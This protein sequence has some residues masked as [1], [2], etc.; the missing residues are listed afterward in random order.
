MCVL[1][2][3]C[4]IAKVMSYNVK[5]MKDVFF[6]FSVQDTQKVVINVIDVND[7]KPEFV[8]KP[9][10]FQTVVSPNAPQGELVYVLDA[11]DKDKDADIIYKIEL[12]LSK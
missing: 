11:R 1:S 10:P 2:S 3:N 7:E 5:L 8:N 6:P 9:K 4:I 12:D